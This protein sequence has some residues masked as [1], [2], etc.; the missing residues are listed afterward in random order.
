[1][2]DMNPTPP[3]QITPDLF[4]KWRSPRRGSANPEQMSN[5][6]WEWLIDSGLSAYQANKA[7]SGPSPFA[8]GP[9]WCFD[10]FGRSSTP[11]ADGRTVLIGGEHEDYYDPDFYIYNDVVVTSPGGAVRIYGYPSA[12]FP[13]TDFHSASLTDREIILIGNLGYPEDRRIGQT[14]VLTVE[15]ETWSVSR[16]DTLGACPGWIHH[17]RAELGADGAGILITGGKVFRGE[18]ASLVENIDDWRL[19]LAGWRWE[20]LTERRWIRFELRRQDGKANHLWALRQALWA[21]EMNWHDRESQA[22]ALETELGTRPQ[23]D[24]LA[25]LYS[26]PVSHEV[27]PKNEDEHNVYRIHVDGVVVRYVE[28]SWSV[29]VT[30]HGELPSDIVERLQQDLTRTLGALEQAPMLCQAILPS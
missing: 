13:P 14:Q 19:H 30:V 7:L 5:P 12:I 20:R 22:L 26:P 4:G 1:M 21:K 28:E 2:S 11:F 24:L 15:R 9:M 29:Q 27:L 17:H 8:A 6:L 23:L 3:P 10:R 16:I 18:D 25:S